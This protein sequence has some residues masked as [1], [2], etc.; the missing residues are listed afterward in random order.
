MGRIGKDERDN[1]VAYLKNCIDEQHYLVPLVNN[2]RTE[3]VLLERRQAAL[4]ARV[5][6]L[7]KLASNR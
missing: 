3:L 4:K 6:E 7:E 1:Q 5:K 2:T